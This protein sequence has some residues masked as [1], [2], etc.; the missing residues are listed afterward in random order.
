[1]AKMMMTTMEK[2]MKE[3]PSGQWADVLASVAYTGNEK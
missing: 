1:M 2:M 3:I